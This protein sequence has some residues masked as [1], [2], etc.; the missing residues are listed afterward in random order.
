MVIW[1]MK[2]PACIVL[3]RRYC[4]IRENA[5]VMPCSDTVLP[6]PTHRLYPYVTC[7]MLRATDRRLGW[8]LQ[9]TAGPCQAE[10]QCSLFRLNLPPIIIS[11]L[12]MADGC[13]AAR[14]QS[15]LDSAFFTQYT[16]LTT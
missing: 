10:A 11:P 15:D 13:G 8:L 5:F 4:V 16:A 2:E 1:C 14:G 7:R 12:G 6:S 3:R 9:G